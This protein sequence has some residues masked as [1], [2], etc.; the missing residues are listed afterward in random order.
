LDSAMQLTGVQT[1]LVYV[2]V[3]GFLLLTINL[4]ERRWR[5]VDEGGRSTVVNGSK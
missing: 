3:F 4:L 1:T 2:A 5:A